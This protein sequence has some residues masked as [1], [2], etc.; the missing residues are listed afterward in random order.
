MAEEFPELVY[1]VGCQLCDEPTLHICIK[2]VPK[3]KK[4]IR[5]KAEM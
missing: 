2:I 1:S 5:L 4:L 3:Q